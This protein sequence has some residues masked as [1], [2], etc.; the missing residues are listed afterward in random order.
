M[1]ILY[2]NFDRGIPVLGD[3]GASVHV[4]E[5]VKAAA[6][7]GHDVLLA[8][9][10]LGTGNAPPPARLVELPLDDSPQLLEKQRAL[11]SIDD[12]TL[13]ATVL[14]R[15]LVRIAYDSEVAARVFDSLA[16]RGF[17]PDF[18]YERHALF[19]SAGV[20]I[21]ARVGCAR[22][23]EVNAPL[24]DEQRRFRGLC[25]EQVAR[26]M[27]SESFRGADHVVTVS[28]A[29]RQ[30]VQ[31]AGGVNSERLHVIPNGVDVRRFGAAYG[32]EALRVR[33][34]F[35]PENCAIG[36]VGSFKPWHGT[37]FLFDVFES[38]AAVR[39]G[40][41]FL[42]VGDGPEWERLRERASSGGYGDRVA[43]VGRIPHA[44][45]P[46]WIAATDIMVAPYQAAPDFYFSPLK[47]VE[48]LA[49]GR[50]VVAP[51]IGQLV[52]LIDHGKNGLLYEVDDAASCREAILELLDDPQRRLAMGRAARAGA[53]EQSWQRVAERVTALAARAAV[54]TAA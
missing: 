18:I 15:E 48:A 17:S 24:V 22:I 10:T 35:S 25:L 4:R 43:L 33:I 26:R 51:R 44:D 28:E 12:S 20:G 2:L 6:D 23:L 39:P 14:R 3:K 38:I 34:G 42:G 41:R 49:S 45:I 7:L 21:A 27:E 47:V 53:A 50:P 31:T 54:R 46:S 9:A 30:H 32:R 1:K 36:F 11:L 40:A 8:C 5:F 16:A 37:G 52:D 29:V 19:S 13:D